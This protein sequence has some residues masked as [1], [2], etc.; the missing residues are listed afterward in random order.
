MI[1]GQYIYIYIYII[2]IIII[3]INAEGL[4]IIH[5]TLLVVVRDQQ[6]RLLTDMLLASI[7]L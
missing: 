3:L 6:R 5:Y 2:V 7:Y 1:N 4:F